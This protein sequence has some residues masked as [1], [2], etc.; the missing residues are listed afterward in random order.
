MKKMIAF[1]AVSV[2]LA[3]CGRSPVQPTRVVNPPLPAVTY[4]VAGTVSEATEDGSRGLAEAT[5][6]VGNDVQSLTASTNENGVFSLE[7]FKAGTWQLSVSKEG[8][9]TQIMML[10]IQGSQTI[11]VE[12]KPAAN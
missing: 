10:D 12:L 8:Y 3:A 5:V 11:E 9:E 7:G 2:L 6:V 1:V 4:V